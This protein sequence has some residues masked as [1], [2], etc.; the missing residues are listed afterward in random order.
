MDCDS[1]NPTVEWFKDG[2]K[3][4]ETEKQEFKGGL[5]QLK[6]AH[7]TAKDSGEYRCKLSTDG[8]AV[9]CQAILRVKGR[10]CQVPFLYLYF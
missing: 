7:T 5:C 8:G 4:S 1:T 9:E 6:F 3:V 2:E 10:L